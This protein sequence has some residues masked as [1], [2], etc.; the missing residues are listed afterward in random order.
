MDI[1]E[2][3]LEGMDWII[4]AEDMAQ[5]QAFVC[6]VINIRV[7]ERL[8]IYLLAERLLASQTSLLACPKSF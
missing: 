3:Q 6:S 4:P 7:W 2:M 5:F 8:G 1:N